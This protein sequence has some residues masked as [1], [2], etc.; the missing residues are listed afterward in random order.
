M[1]KIQTEL[2]MLEA[3]ELLIKRKIK[4]QKFTKIAKEVFELMGLS[5]AED[6]DIRTAQL[7][8]DLSLSGKFVATGE[9]MWDLKSRQLYE[10]ANYDTYELDFETEEPI[11]LLGED[12]PDAAL[13]SPDRMMITDDEDDDNGDDDSDDST[14]LVSDDYGDD[15]DAEIENE[16]NDQH[17]GLSIYRT[18]EMD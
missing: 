4:P 3:A 5:G 16:E 6:L 2:S 1:A 8:T 14:T 18:E 9:D 13:I 10:T 15:S 7:Y 17:A 12:A 11:T